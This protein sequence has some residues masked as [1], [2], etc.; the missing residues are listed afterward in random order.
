MAKVGSNIFAQMIQRNL[1][2]HSSELQEVYQRLASGRRINRPADDP[3]GHALAESLNLQS[4]IAN[5][6]MNSINDVI[7]LTSIAG[8]AVEA[9]TK[10]ITRLQELAT[11][12]SNETFTVEQRVVID[13]EAQALAAEYNRIARSTTWNGYRIFDASFGTINLSTSN[14]AA[15]N[16][17]STLGGAIGTGAL[18]AETTYA[19]AAGES[20]AQLAD[21]NGDG[22]PD[23]AAVANGGQ[24]NILLGNGD[25]TFRTGS[26]FS[27]VTSFYL[28]AADLNNDSK[29]DLVLSSN[30]SGGLHTYLGN[31]DGTFT[32]KGASSTSGTMQDVQLYDFTGDGILDA[33]AISD[34]TSQVNI[35]Q[36]NGD[37]TFTLSQTIAAPS[38]P[39]GIEVGDFTGDGQADIIA[40]GN[41]SGGHK[42]YVNQGGGTFATG[43]DIAGALS[44]NIQAVGDFNEDGKLDFVAVDANQARLSLYLGNGNGSFQ[45]PTYLPTGGF[46]YGARVLDINGDGHLDLAATSITSNYLQILLGNGDG[47]FQSAQTYST[48]GSPRFPDVGDVNGDGVPD[49]VV[50]KYTAGTINVLIAETTA[51]IGNLQPFSL[52]YMAEAH[53]AYAEFGRRHAAL[54]RQ[55]AHI[56]AFRERLEFAV[57]QQRT[58]RD[59]LKEAES[60]IVDIDVAQE[61]AT[62]VRAQI[63]QQ[64]AAALLAQSNKD[65]EV[66]TRLLGI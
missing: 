45:S 18:G 60:R 43:T 37:G 21:F 64:F 15:G 39:F 62:L 35:L 19:G 47:T 27:T 40:S 34:G 3:S 7:S 48:G 58:L 12:A 61:A 29:M 54:V 50:P 8:N 10:V 16:I 20:E 25:G 33:A 46:P 6:R 38:N 1:G 59:A 9:L 24:I 5:Q 36:G 26:A 66:V 31:G 56:G 13:K 30:V 2:R 22:I 17:S 41:T 14:S 23:I 53:E 49:V 65:T 11:Q 4:R 28:K 51:G 63:G 44:N 52:L 57:S 42:I 55:Q 32:Y